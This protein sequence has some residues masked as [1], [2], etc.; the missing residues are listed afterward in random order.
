MPCKTKYSRNPV[1][2]FTSKLRSFKRRTQL[3][4]KTVAN[5][6]NAIEGYITKG[7]GRGYISSRQITKL[8]R[9]QDKLAKLYTDTLS[10]Y[11]LLKAT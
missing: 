5:L 7:M 10:I 9:A 4:G 3:Y 11:G 6:H 1:T 2:G 8:R